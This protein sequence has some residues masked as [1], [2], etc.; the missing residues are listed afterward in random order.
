M[1]Y[2]VTIS[3]EDNISIPGIGVIRGMVRYWPPCSGNYIN[4]PEGADMEVLF[5]KDSD[6]K[7]VILDF[8]DDDLFNYFLEKIEEVL[9][10]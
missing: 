5:L 9:Y 6:G 10:R 7:E 1:P 8:D 4:P 3:E 2:P